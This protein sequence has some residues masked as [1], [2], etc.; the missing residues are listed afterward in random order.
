MSPNGLEE[1]SMFMADLQIIVVGP[2]FES[3]LQRRILKKKQCRKGRALLA[4]ETLEISLRINIRIHSHHIY[5]LCLPF[6]IVTKYICSPQ[7][8][9]L[10]AIQYL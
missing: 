5:L 8:N 3:L 4:T 10:L 2:L 7:L 6:D 9:D 1:A